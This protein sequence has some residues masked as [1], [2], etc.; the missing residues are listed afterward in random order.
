MWLLKKKYTYVLEPNPEE[1]H[2]KRTASPSF[3]IQCWTNITMHFV[4]VK[5]L[6]ILKWPKL[7]TS[8]SNVGMRLY[9]SGS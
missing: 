5:V 8:R 1:K 3:G 4:M 7:A 6:K 2:K 9:T